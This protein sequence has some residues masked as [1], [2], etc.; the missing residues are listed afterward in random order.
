MKISVA[1]VSGNRIQMNRT[2]CMLDEYAEKRDEQYLPE[3]FSSGQSF[4]ADLDRRG[5]YDLY[6]FN[7][8]MPDVNGIK[9]AETIRKRGDW[10]QLLLIN[11]DGSYAAH[12]CRVE[13]RRY[14]TQ[15][16][17]K[18]HFY[19]AMDRVTEMIKADDISTIVELKLKKGYMRVPVSDIMYVAVENR[20]ICYH[21]KD[22]SRHSTVQLRGKF[23]EMT[24]ELLE[25]R[26][27][28]RAGN[29]Y[30]INM[31]HLKYVSNDRIIMKNDEE[32][33]PS[34]KACAEVLE[35]WRNYV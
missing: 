6:I 12:A 31:Q 7:V 16:L 14:L 28:C 13:A 10:H 18:D 25:H 33:R 4:L 23:R 5:E 3:Y 1:V 17:T 29:S 30:V 35:A 8:Q 32:L 9:L 27:F 24:E 19:E 20:A 22:G 15:P 34:L 21:L 11:G 2:A 26:A